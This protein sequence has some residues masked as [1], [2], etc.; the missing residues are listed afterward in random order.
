MLRKHSKEDLLKVQEEKRK[1]YY[2][3]RIKPRSYK[4]GDLVAI[5]RTTVLR[6]K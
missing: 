3:R 1:G 2:L 6:S 5:K 4:E